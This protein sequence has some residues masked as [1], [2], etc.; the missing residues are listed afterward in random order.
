MGGACDPDD[1]FS[2]A[3]PDEVAL[4][5]LAGEIVQLL[6]AAPEGD[7]VHAPLALPLA[8]SA[9][10]ARHCVDPEGLIDAML[11]LRRALIVVAALD[12]ASEPVP[13]TAGDPHDA[14][15]HLARYLHGLLIRAAAACQLQREA[16]AS[17]AAEQLRIA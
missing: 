8:L 15:V 3:D 12:A 6:A 2:A 16:L 7:A 14:A 1:G 4:V 11:P 10:M 13:L 9:C 17:A 5:H